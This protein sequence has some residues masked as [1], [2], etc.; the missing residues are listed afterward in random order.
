MKLFLP[1]SR[2]LVTWPSKN[3]FF[4]HDSS[5]WGVIFTLRHAGW[6][7][8]TISVKKYV[9]TYLQISK[10]FKYKD[11]WKFLGEWF[12]ISYLWHSTQS[13]E[14][15]LG[16]HSANMDCLVDTSEFCKYFSMTPSVLLL[17]WC[18]IWYCILDRRIFKGLLYLMFAWT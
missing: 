15:S 16:R 3:Q 1:F 6:F 5:A 8:I 13:T 11:F 10:I 12:G 17:V 4:A 9:G 18:K 2:A 14:R 7:G